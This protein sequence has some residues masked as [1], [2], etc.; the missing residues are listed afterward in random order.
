MAFAQ[1]NKAAPVYMQRQA[2]GEYYH[3]ERYIGIDPR[4]P[5]L[6][7]VKL[8]DGDYRLDEE[9]YVFTGASGRRLWPQSNLELTRRHDGQQ[10]QDDF[11]HEQYL[12]V[13]QDGWKL[14]LSGCAHNGI[15]NILDRY[16]ELFHSMPDAVISGFHMKKKR[17]YGDDEIKDIKE[18]ARELANLDTV[19]YT[20]HCTGQDAFDIMKGVMG[21]KLRP[22]QSGTEI[23]L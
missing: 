17:A 2:V 12:V 15:L 14:L 23:I 10:A 9:L 19:F 6:P 18:T 8:M 21:D 4:I 7:Q 13:S 5:G 20:G 22:V 11:A 3:G 1:I 16:K